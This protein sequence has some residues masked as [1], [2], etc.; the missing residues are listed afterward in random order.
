[1][2][3]E[4][5][6]YYFTFDATGHAGVD[7]I[8]ELVAKAGKG[9]HHTRDWDD[10]DLTRYYDSAYADGDKTIIQQIQDAAN[11]LAKDQLK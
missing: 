7:R 5:R 6:A 10:P 11:Q 2:G 1:M 3:F 8:L 9:F 4:F